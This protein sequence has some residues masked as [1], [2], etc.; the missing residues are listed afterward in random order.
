MPSKFQSISLVVLLGTVFGLN[1][2][3]ARFSTGQFEPLVYVSLRA[4][5]A[6]ILHLAIYPLKPELRFP[7]SRRLW[8]HAGVFGF[9]GVVMTMVGY[10]SS[11]R[12]LSSGVMSLFLTLTMPAT[13][14]LA[15]FFL[16]DERMNPYK[17]LG[18]FVAFAGAMALLISRETGIADIARADWRGYAFIIMGVA[19][20]SASGVYARRFLKD[21]P[22]YDVSTIRMLVAAAI[23]IPIAGLS[24]GYDLSSVRVSGYMALLYHAVIGTF[25][26]FLLNLYIINK[27]S[28]TAGSESSYISP[29]VATVLGAMLLDEIVTPIMIVGM[30]LIFA[31]LTI[32]NWAPD[33]QKQ[34]HHMV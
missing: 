17:V 30:V 19:G 8:L 13:V 3:A 10:V 2:V 31:G 14:I 32:L 9:L 11:L 4:A 16:S 1:I 23:L 29:V 21:D 7:T 27:F 15:H 34:D 6:S 25:L 18:V 26:A 5:I 24:I 33:T 28:A 12:Y 20:A 22:N